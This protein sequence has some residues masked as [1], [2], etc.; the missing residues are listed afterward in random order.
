MAVIFE[1]FQGV[2]LIIHLIL[3]L[4]LVFTL[5]YSYIVLIKQIK[6]DSTK[7]E[8]Y[9]KVVTYSMLLYFCT[10]FV[11]IAIYPIFK[12]NVMVPYF[13]KDLPVLAGLFEIKEHVGGIAVIPAL[14][15]I[16]LN[17]LFDLSKSENRQKFILCVQLTTI[18]AFATFLKMILGFVFVAARSI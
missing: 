6:V 18:V 9:K 17:K 10:W 11:G 16:L 8:T 13:D 3:A 2:L 1:G 12:V 7:F 14:A 5:V 15:V 4:S